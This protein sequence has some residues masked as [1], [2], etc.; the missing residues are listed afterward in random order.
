[1]YWSGVGGYRRK[2][3]IIGEGLARAEAGWGSGRDN[4]PLLTS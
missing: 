1:M 4:D 2:W 3:E